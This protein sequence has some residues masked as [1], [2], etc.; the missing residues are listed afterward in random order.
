MKHCVRLQLQACVEQS[1]VLCSDRGELP[2]AVLAGQ[3]AAVQAVSCGG[4]QCIF[5]S[6]R[7]LHA[8]PCLYVRVQ[9]CSAGPGALLRL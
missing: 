7:S 4:A 2:R 1:A 8:A 6:L 5:V 3:P 9:L